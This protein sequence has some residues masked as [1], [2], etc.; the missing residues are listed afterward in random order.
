MGD[1]YDNALCESVIGLYKTE[2]IERLGPWRTVEAVELATMDW[3]HW[4]N[5]E[6]VFARLGYRSPAE[7]EAQYHHPQRPPPS[8]A[9]PTG[10]RQLTL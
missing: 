10:R 4:F 9:K 6:R 7:Y 3:V 8:P 5:H 1:A 2:V